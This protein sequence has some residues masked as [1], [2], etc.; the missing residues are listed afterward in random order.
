MARICHPIT[1][2]FHGRD[3]FEK[4]DGDYYSNNKLLFGKGYRVDWIDGV[5]DDVIYSNFCDSGHRGPTR[6]NGMVCWL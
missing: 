6:S 3:D 5:A 2:E 1:E 4:F